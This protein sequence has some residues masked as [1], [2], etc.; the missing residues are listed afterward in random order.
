MAG[1]RPNP[2]NEDD[3]NRRSFEYLGYGNRWFDRTEARR[4]RSLLITAAF[5]FIGLLVV[6]LTRWLGI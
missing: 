4:R 1:Y 3:V 6:L 5:G 2:E